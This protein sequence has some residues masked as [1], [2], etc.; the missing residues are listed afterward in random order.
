MRAVSFVFT[1]ALAV[2]ALASLPALAQREYRG[3]DQGL[4]KPSMNLRH[5]PASGSGE[6][7]CMGW[8]LTGEKLTTCRQQWMEA[9]TDADR[10]AVRNQ[11]APEKGGVWGQVRDSH[12]PIADPDATTPCD[13]WHLSAADLTQCRAEWKSARNDA[14]RD[15]LRRRYAAVGHGDQAGSRIEPAPQRAPTDNGGVPRAQ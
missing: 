8:N 2:A 13:T 1:S 9:K 3:P 6:D 7:V 4:A 10:L 12:K 5:P 15:K 11:Y 14:D